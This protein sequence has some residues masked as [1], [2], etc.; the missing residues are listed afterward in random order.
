MTMQIAIELLRYPTHESRLG[1]YQALQNEIARVPGVRVAALG[2]DVPFDGWNGGQLFSVAGTASDD[3]SPHPPAHYQPIGP[4]YFEALG[5][6]LLRG[7]AFTDRD[8]NTS[9]PVCIVNEEFAR[10]YLS[11]RDP[12]GA[13][14]DMQTVALAPAKVT[15]EVVGVVAQVK[16]RPGCPRQSDRDLRS[17]RAE[18]LVLDDGRGARRGAAGDARA[19]HSSRRRSGPKGSAVH[20]HPNNGG[21]GGAGDGDAAVSRAAGRRVRGARNGACRCRRVQRLQV[22][23][24]AARARVFD[25]DG[26]RRAVGSRGSR[27]F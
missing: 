8:H 15:R 1:L 20:A 22:C 16:E 25:S 4:S 9:T 12:I 26:P 7:R 23:R 19:G 3:P 5:I 18:L 14:I 21:H 27:G 2:N 6:P 17:Y 24:A 10:R 11:S 13:K